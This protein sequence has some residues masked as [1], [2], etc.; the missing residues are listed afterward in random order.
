[1]NGVSLRVITGSDNAPYAPSEEAWLSV[2]PMRCMVL[3][4]QD[5]SR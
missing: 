4:V 5:A 1:V 2:P 3:P